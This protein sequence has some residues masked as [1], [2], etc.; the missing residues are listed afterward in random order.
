[1]QILSLRFSTTIT[2]A[3][4]L[5]LKFLTQQYESG[6]SFWLNFKEMELYL[7]Y[8]ADRRMEELGFGAFYG[9]D[10]NPLKFLEKQDVMTLQNF[11]EV[12]PNQYT[13]S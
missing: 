5:E 1:M 4:D 6:I 3:V 12:T 8:I 2:D 9:V 10:H 7:K 11:F 13:N